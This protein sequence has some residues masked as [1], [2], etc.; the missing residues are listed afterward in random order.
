MGSCYRRHLFPSC[1]LE[2]GLCLD[3]SLLCCSLL[4]SSPSFQPGAVGNQRP[5]LRR[6]LLY[7]SLSFSFGL[8]GVG[9]LAL[10]LNDAAGGYGSFP[11]GYRFL[12]LN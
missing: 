6:E 12:S 11:L 3:G 5:K 10:R 8:R 1:V 9:R 7:S 2:A 4:F